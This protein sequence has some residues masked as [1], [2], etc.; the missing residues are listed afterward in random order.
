MF[1]SCIN[2]TYLQCLCNII[3][4]FAWLVFS[5]LRNF[6]Y[7]L[8]VSWN[9]KNT[10]D[11]CFSLKYLNISLTFTLFSLFTFCDTLNASF[12]LT[13]KFLVGQ[14]FKYLVRLHSLRMFHVPYFQNMFANSGISIKISHYSKDLLLISKVSDSWMVSLVVKGFLIFVSQKCL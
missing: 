5:L 11:F 9:F 6:S 14:I 3:P 2:I 1:C 7:P 4:Q 12:R 8:L 10:D 13:K